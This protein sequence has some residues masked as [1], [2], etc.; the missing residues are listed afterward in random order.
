MCESLY[1]I[2]YHG[3]RGNNELRAKRLET[4]NQQIEWWLKVDPEL[5]IKIL[6]MDYDSDDYCNHPNVTYIGKSTHPIPPANAR[7]ILLK[8]F[9]ESDEQWGAFADSDAI[10]NYHE[11]FSHT[12]LNITKILRESGDRFKDV[13]LFV[14]HND[15]RPGD[16]A[17]YDKYN[18]VDPEYKDVDWN[19]EFVFDRKLTHM[20]GTLFFLR[21]NDSTL[22]MDDQFSTHPTGKKA[23]LGGEDDEF[24][25]N[26]VMNNHGTYMLRNIMLKELTT[27]STW[28]DTTDR[29]AEEGYRDDIIREKHNL[30]LDRSK[31]TRYIK[32]THTGF[33]K[34]LRIQLNETQD[35]QTFNSIFEF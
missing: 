34:Q 35:E 17:F 21:N 1:I 12:H 14:P 2:A 24:M 25:V 30:P 13:T 28:S 18:C 16:G 22:M 19:N 32:S 10:L 6:A 31:W 29:K 8:H 20:K 33:K 23:F 5:K 3:N 11:K 26:H 15:Q 7:N 9:Y 4:H 27:A